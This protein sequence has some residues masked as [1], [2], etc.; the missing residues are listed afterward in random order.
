MKL[1]PHSCTVFLL[2]GNPV[3]LLQHNSGVYS[4][5]LGE[6]YQAGRECR[7]V[8]SDARGFFIGQPGMQH[9][10]AQERENCFA[11]NLDFRVNFPASTEAL[12][13]LGSC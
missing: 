11:P 13:L 12:V 5:T 9:L 2:Y 7:A 3:A 6:L 10:L 1:V 8:V 4:E